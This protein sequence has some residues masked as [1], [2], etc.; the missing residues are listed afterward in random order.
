[1]GVP[2][3]LL[4]AWALAGAVLVAPAVSALGSLAPAGW[5]RAS[6]ARISF[7]YPPGWRLDRGAYYSRAVATLVLSPQFRSPTPLPREK[8]TLVPPLVSQGG[9]VLVYDVKPPWGE[10]LNSG[11]SSHCV[12]ACR[13]FR[14]NGHP[15]Q[16]RTVSGEG[17]Q[18]MTL[19]EVRLG[20]TRTFEVAH[21]YPRG[22][23]GRTAAL[24]ARIVRSAVSR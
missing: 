14:V 1:M 6:S 5:H 17:G 13:A 8:D 4:G 12:R 2:R 3:A 21:L 22:Q 9:A 19:T 11:W 10:F 16:R 18:Y 7:A 23:E 20:R 24:Y 15:A